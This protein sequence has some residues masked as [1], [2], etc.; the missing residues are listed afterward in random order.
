MPLSGSWR[1]GSKQ[2]IVLV[3]LVP[4][5]ILKHPVDHMRLSHAQILGNILLCRQRNFQINL[6]ANYKLHKLQITHQITNYKLKKHGHHLDLSML[7]MA[8][9]FVSILDLRRLSS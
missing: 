3:N 4:G 6:Y 2:E 9:Y 1:S 5:V 7:K 8:L